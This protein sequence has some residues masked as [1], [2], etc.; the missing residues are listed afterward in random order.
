MIYKRKGY[1]ALVIRCRILGTEVPEDI[2]E[3]S[4]YDNPATMDMT[5]MVNLALIIDPRE[6]PEGGNYI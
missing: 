5:Q 6:T 4:S 3:C 1:T 2:N